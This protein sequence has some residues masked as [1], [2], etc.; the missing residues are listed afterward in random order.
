MIFGTSIPKA[1]GHQ[2]AVQFPT[3]PSMCFYTT[4]GNR[5]NEICTEMNNKRQQTGD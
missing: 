2:M 3:S 5:T 4:W 1:T